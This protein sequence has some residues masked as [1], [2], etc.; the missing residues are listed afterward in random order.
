MVNQV[1]KYLDYT[2]TLIIKYLINKLNKLFIFITNIA[3]A[4]YMDQKLFKG[5]I[6][7]IFGRIVD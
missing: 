6:F 7:K 5:Y 3:Y 2:Y 4:D 1:I